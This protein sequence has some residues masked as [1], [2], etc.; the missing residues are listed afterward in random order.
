MNPGAM[1]LSWYKQLDFGRRENKLRQS[2]DA[3]C[4]WGGLETSCLLWGKLV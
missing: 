3:F 1:E 2:S 4:G